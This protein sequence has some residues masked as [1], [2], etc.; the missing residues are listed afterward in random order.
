MKEKEEECN[1]VG[2][3]SVGRSLGLNATP[4]AVPETPLRVPVQQV[5]AC[6][7]LMKEGIRNKRPEAF[8]G[9]AATAGRSSGARYNASILG[10]VLFMP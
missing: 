9:V 6:E 8:F 10:W 3:G 7:G 1:A 4:S 2:V 5:G